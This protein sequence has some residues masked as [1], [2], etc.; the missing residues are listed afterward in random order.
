MVDDCGR[1][2]RAALLLFLLGGMASERQTVVAGGVVRPLVVVS[3]PVR[4]GMVDDCGRGRRA[5]P[6][7][8]LSAGVV[9]KRQTMVAGGVLRPLV[10]E[11]NGSGIPATV[12]CPVRAK[13]G[14]A[15]GG[16]TLEVGSSIPEMVGYLLFFSACRVRNS[17]LL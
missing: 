4:Q 1:G 15:S 12:E 2:R 11:A 9:S 14:Q 16:S 3:Q 6:L 10:V 8:F 13:A 5:T 7:L 17:G